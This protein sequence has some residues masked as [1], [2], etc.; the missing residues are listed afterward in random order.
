MHIKDKSDG[1]ISYIRGAYIRRGGRE[2]DRGLHLAEKKIN[3]QSVK[4]A[5]LSFFYHKA[6]ILGY[7][8]SCKM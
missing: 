6:R 8:T 7:F 3:L 1:P 5:F 2:G 4:I